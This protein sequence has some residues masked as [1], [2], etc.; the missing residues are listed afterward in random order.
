MLN[1]R[2]P[3]ESTATMDMTP[4]EAAA[5]EAEI[6]AEFGRVSRA[7]LEG[8]GGGE[9]LP[10]ERAYLGD[11]RCLRTTGLGGGSGGGNGGGSGGGG[12][13][14]EA[15]A[16]GP[17]PASFGAADLAF[18]ALAGWVVLPPG[19][20]AGACDVPG[21]ADMPPAAAALVRELRATPAGRHVTR[22]YADHRAVGD[23][24]STG[25]RSLPTLLRRQRTRRPR[26]TAGTGPLS[27]QGK[28]LHCP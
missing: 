5:A 11:G 8:G 28:F 19:F 1:Q 6:R 20:H 26:H 18:C 23:P 27:S 9:A 25:P 7:L 24:L 13:G 21:L 12:G 14:G 10:L 3:S 16:P 17:C 15:A 2:P 4:A 22:C